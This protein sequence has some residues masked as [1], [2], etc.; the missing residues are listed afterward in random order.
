[1][2]RRLALETC[3]EEKINVKSFV[4]LQFCLEEVRE[5]KRTHL[6][7]NY[8]YFLIHLEPYSDITEERSQ[9]CYAGTVSHC[10]DNFL[11]LFGWTVGG[12]VGVSR[13]VVDHPAPLDRGS[14]IVI[15]L[16][17]KL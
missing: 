5:N 11:T 17:R 14:W 15:A 1:M 2:N 3:R 13:R 6:E 4:K 12:R 7:T 10:C 16:S 8:G 9:N